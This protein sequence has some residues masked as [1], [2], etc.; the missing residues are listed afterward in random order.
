MCARR[1]R[2]HAAPINR[3]AATVRIQEVAEFEGTIT[4]SNEKER[5]I[6][7]CL[8]GLGLLEVVLG[9]L[10]VVLGRGRRFS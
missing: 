2:L 6:T 4:V 3:D 8:Q 9:E 5:L 10:A 1:P 7:I